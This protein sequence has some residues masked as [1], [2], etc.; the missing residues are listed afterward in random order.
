MTSR[1]CRSAGRARPERGGARYWAQAGPQGAP[2]WGSDLD[3]VGVERL[4]D[5]DLDGVLRRRWVVAVSKGSRGA[6]FSSFSNFPKRAF[7]RIF[8]TC[9]QL[10]SMLWPTCPHLGGEGASLSESPAKR[11][12]LLASLG[13]PC[14]LGNYSQ[15]RF[16][17]GDLL[18]EIQK[19]GL[20]KLDP[21]ANFSNKKKQEKARG[22]DW[23]SW[24]VHK[25]IIACQSTRN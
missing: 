16:G 24:C 20:E 3:A 13:K 19:V 6:Q 14:R 25:K 22:L 2:W 17:L 11:V 12:A 5:V 15:G 18:A 1:T 4:R 8:C 10:F 9:S 23:V 21:L 7:F